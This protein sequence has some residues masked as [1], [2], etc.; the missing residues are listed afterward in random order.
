MTHKITFFFVVIKRK[1]LKKQIGKTRSKV[2]R[3]D[4]RQAKQKKR[5]RN[6]IKKINEIK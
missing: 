5:E 3:K 2:A 4:C 1:K 6:L